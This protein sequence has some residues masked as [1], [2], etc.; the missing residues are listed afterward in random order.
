[1]NR[2]VGTTVLISLCLL[3]APLLSARGSG[4]VDA[5]ALWNESLIE[6][7]RG[8]A[9]SLTE[10]RF[11]NSEL[12]GRTSGSDAELAAA[13]WLALQKR[14]I[15]LRK[16]TV[17]PYQCDTWQFNGATLAVAEG[18]GERRVLKPYSYASGGTGANGIT[19][20]LLYLGR[21]TEADYKE[22]DARGRI[23]LIDIDMDADWW[24]EYPTIEAALHGAAAVVSSC[25]GGYATINDDAMN[26]QDFCGPVTIPSVNISRN[27]AS[28]LKRLLEAG[29]VTVTLTV[30]NVVRKGGIGKNITGMIPGRNDDEFIIVGDH[31]DVHFQGFQDNSTGVAMTLA[32]AKAMIDGGY[33]PE[34]TILFVLH[35]GEEWGAIDTRYDWAIGSWNQVNRV[36]PDWAGK[37]LCYLNFEHPAHR[38]GNVFYLK[39]AVELSDYLLSFY[40]QAPDPSELFPDGFIEEGSHLTTWTD[41]WSYNIAGIPS[42]NNGGDTLDDGD[43]GIDSYYHSQF[44]TA[45]TWD[46]SIFGY[47][48]RFYLGLV[49]AVERAPALELNL[50]RQSPRLSDSIDEQAF[51]SAGIDPAD[52]RNAVSRF[53]LAAAARWNEL[54]EINRIFRE[55]KE[56]GA[57][58]MVLTTIRERAR[59]ANAD[60]LAAFSAFQKRMYRLDWSDSPIFGHEQPQ[61]NVRVLSEAIELLSGGQAAGSAAS[62]AVDTVLDELLWQVDDAWYSYSFSRE[63][64]QYHRDQVFSE[65]NRGNLFW[66]TG[67]IV[68]LCDIHDTI[69]SLLA[70]YGDPKADCSAEAAQLSLRLQEQKALLDRLVREETANLTEITRMLERSSI[71]SVLAGIQGLARSK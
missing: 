63:N 60:I 41:A 6:Y 3:P 19:A 28:Y 13:D 71:P 58:A 31:Y 47:N 1:M 4:E 9:V 21:G 43:E 14:E 65:W 39:S 23:V 52:F 45:D 70:K 57:S 35:G 59:A 27:D 42:M 51:A 18:R 37:A 2:I 56:R 46:A 33:R 50:A 32:I 24:I 48:L 66:G 7:A 62:P 69:R 40:G 64:V 38:Y 22:V 54:R 36:T 26:A 25:S 15:G 10:R 44:D 12:G 20:E 17:H 53:E 55:L 49:S 61:T 5:E 11:L 16:V 68:G 34:R 30:D 8:I 67:M 29:P